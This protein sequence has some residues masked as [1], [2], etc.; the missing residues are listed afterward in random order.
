LYSI[1]RNV[2]AV[3][4]LE[5]RLALWEDQNF[6]GLLVRVQKQAESRN[7]ILGESLKTGAN[8]AASQRARRLAKEGARSKA[9]AGL[10]GGIKPLTTEQQHDWSAKLLPQ[11][12]HPLPAVAAGPPTPSTTQGLRGPD[13]HPLKDVR[14]PPMTAPGPSLT[15]PEHIQ[16][17]LGVRRRCVAN[18]FLRAIGRAV[19]LGLRGELPEAARWILGSGVTFLEK[20]GKDAPR[21]IR[22]GEWLRKVISK[23]LLNRHRKQIQ[24]LMISLHQFGVA[25]PGGCEA[26]FHA[27]DTIEEVARSGSLPPL[28]IIDVDLVNCFGSFEWDAIV[29]ACE[30][31]FPEGVP[32]ER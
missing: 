27:R 23:S 13:V 9:V 18:R 6:D 16:D 20:P 15:R 1:P 32:W 24:K 22:A 21:P 25:M 7:I 26:L 17:M 10:Q 28:A 8:K 30:E 14:F 3:I 4:E 2:P 19:D 12:D 11:A 29:G 31:L 5:Q